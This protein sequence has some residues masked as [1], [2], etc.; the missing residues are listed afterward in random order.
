VARILDWVPDRARHSV[1]HDLIDVGR[2]QP[3]IQALPYVDSTSD[4]SDI[5]RPLPVKDFGITNQTVGSLCEAFG[6]RLHECRFKTGRFEDVSIVWVHSLFQ[7]RVESIGKAL[8]RQ[9]DSRVHQ[10]ETRPHVQREKAA[11]LVRPG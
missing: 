5:K 4:H 2:H 9:I 11:E 1:G 6:G 10:A 3:V 8:G 7:R